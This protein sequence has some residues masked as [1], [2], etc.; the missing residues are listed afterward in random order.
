MRKLCNFCRGTKR[1]EVLPGREEICQYCNNGFVDEPGVRNVP[2]NVEIKYEDRRCKVV[3]VMYNDPTGQPLPFPYTMVVTNEYTSSLPY[4]DVNGRTEVLMQDTVRQAAGTVFDPCEGA[5]KE[6]ELPEQAA[7]RE[8][9][10]EAG[11]AHDDIDEMW[12]VGMA[13][14]QSD[15]G[16]GAMPIVGQPLQPKVAHVYLARIREDAELGKQL[17]DAEEQIKVAW[18]DLDDAIMLVEEQGRETG[19]TP[20]LINCLRILKIRRLEA[21]KA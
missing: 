18:Y 13:Y 20:N 17:L 9:C 21:E 4:R 7:R 10:E 3:D 12:F 14:Q 1:W 5:I 2:T 8:I 16:L 19:F 11:I 15:R 6:S